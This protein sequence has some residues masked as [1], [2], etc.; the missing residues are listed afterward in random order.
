MSATG[1]KTARATGAVVRVTED[2]VGKKVVNFSGESA[3]EIKELMI[4]SPAGCVTY[5]ILSFG[6][7]LGMGDK[8]FAVPWR[9][10][11][12][13]RTRDV[14]MMK[15][16]KELLSNAPGFDKII[17][18]ICLIRLAFRRL[19]N[20]TI[21]NPQGINSKIRTLGTRRGRFP[22]GGRSCRASSWKGC[23]SFTQLPFWIAFEANIS[24]CHCRAR[25]SYWRIP[26][27][28]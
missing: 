7:F 26:F 21:P 2:V 11:S 28:V 25:H 16:N 1:P 17:G 5:A 3:G 9:R 24:P 10:L 14:F 6:G 19:T 12:Y 23:G 22:I 8:L 27:D 18:P 13:D 15:V 4:D 20:T